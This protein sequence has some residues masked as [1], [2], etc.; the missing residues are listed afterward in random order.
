MKKEHVKHIL[1]EYFRKTGNIPKISQSA[2]ELGIST[3]QVRKLFG[4]WNQAL[5][6]SGLSL[7]RKHAINTTCT[8]CNARI[9][10][11]PS[12]LNKSQH[13]FCS[14]SCA[15]SYNNKLRIQTE[16]TKKKISN[17]LKQHIVPVNIREKMIKNRWANYVPTP[18][19]S[20]IRR[21]YVYVKTCTCCNG[22]FFSSNKTVKYCSDKC[23]KITASIRM[24]HWLKHN[25][26]HVR[27]PHKQS[28]MEKSFEQWLQQNNIHKGLSG[29]LTEVY[30]FND[31]TK[32]NGWADF[33]FPR[34][35]LIVEL[36][37]THHIKRKHL[38][39]IRDDYL[40]SR[41]WL[42]VRISHKEFRSKSKLTLVKQLLNI[43]R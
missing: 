15:A 43:G 27:G 6:Y 1:G 2:V 26:S 40:T 39:N 30:F 18:R 13:N 38:D 19:G 4:T 8:N 11:Q 36:D 32:K 28:Y 35:R 14:S 7:N 29:Y 21:Q 41:G 23:R 33:V 9:L 34:K 10:V 20:Y 24:S 17:T 31:Q 5:E 3:T 12:K 16:S 37:G 22:V 42:V 25:R